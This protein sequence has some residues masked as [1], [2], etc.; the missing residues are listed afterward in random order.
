MKRLGKKIAAFGCAVILMSALLAA[1]PISAHAMQIFISVAVED[2]RRSF[3]LEVETGDTIEAIKAKI[4]EK[5]DI[6]PQVQ[7][8]TYEGDEL[9]D[10]RTLGDYAIGKDATLYLEIQKLGLSADMFCFM[11]PDSL[12]Y[13]GAEK[14]A[15]IEPAP[16]VTGVGEITVKYYDADGGLINGAP[17]T[18]GTYTVKVD[19]RES[20]LYGAAENISSDTWR[21]TVG[22]LPLPDPLYTVTGF[23][24]QVGDIYYAKGNGSMQLIAPGGYGIGTAPDGVF[25]DRLTLTADSAV[26]VIYLKADSGTVTDAIDVTGRFV[27]DGQAPTLKGVYNGKT[28]YG[29]LEVRIPSGSDIESVTLDGAPMTFTDGLGKVAADNQTHVLVVTDFVGNTTQYTVTVKTGHV[30]TFLADGQVVATVMVEHGQDAA[31]PAVPEKEGCTQTPPA[32]D[33]DGKNITKDME[34]RA[35][36]TVNEYT[37]TFLVDGQVYKTEKY[38]H[39]DRVQVPPVPGK[40]GYTGAWDR[41]VETATEDVAVNAVYTAA[42]PAGKPE[43]EENGTWWLWLG[44]VL[45]AGGVIAGS[46]ALVKKKQ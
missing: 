13:D 2:G 46:V 42:K 19:V 9:E 10:G 40:T 22:P 31:M 28:Y 8:L 21:F 5:E 14:T 6:L 25:E 23:V 43:K 41:K 16:H 32:W 18:P 26:T 39:G 45:S 27:F 11:P 38:R 37:V 12:I 7:V 20:A 34:I 1:L 3:T 17:V 29:D 24:K 44:I 36:Y 33:H 15:T 30:V 35:V 4:R